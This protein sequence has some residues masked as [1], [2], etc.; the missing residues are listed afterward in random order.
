MSKKLLSL[1]MALS[2]VSGAF[3]FSVT[4]QVDMSQ[5]SGFTTPEVNGSFNNWCGNCFPMSDANGDNIWEA[6]TD[7]PAGTYEFK[8]SA[9][10]WGSQETL[11]AGT[12]CTVT[13]FGFTNRTLAVSADVV[14]PVV[15]WGSCTDC[16][17]T[18]NV[19]QVEFQVDMNGIT[20]FT[21]PEVN[22][23]FNGWCGNCT[24]L[25]DPDGDN[26]WSMVVS[27]QEGYYEYKFSYDNWAGQETLAPGSSCTVTTDIYTNR[28]LNLN[29]D[30]TLDPVCWGSCDLC[31]QG[32]GPY[33]VTFAVDMSQVGFAYNTPEVNGTFNNWCGNCAP[34]SDADGDHIWTITIP[35]PAGTHAYKFSYDNW[36]G[37]EELIP[38]SACTITDSGFTNRTIDVAEPTTLA[39]VCWSSCE[40]CVVGVDEKKET[41]FTVYPNPV[42]DI[43]NLVISKNEMTEI[44]VCD[45]TGRALL[46]SN[47]QG[48][49]STQLDVSNLTSGTYVVTLRNK[50]ELLREVIQ[51]IR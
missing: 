20:G 22:G 47:V 24:A 34:M 50:S 3:A 18:P 28:T 39:N 2:L 32:S 17:S 44:S 11:L 37:Q 48:G 8:F 12:A 49:R 36:T 30:I 9:D 16:A 35:L 38:G 23:T 45:M 51:V 43:L 27:L 42:R 46:T 26:V 21:T 15:C 5:Q 19:Y 29:S 14:L 13:S 33:N 1:F 10:N 6:T 31:G 4:F 41:T 7:L 40:A 25:A